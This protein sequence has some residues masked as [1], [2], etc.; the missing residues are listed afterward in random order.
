MTHANS[1]VFIVF[2]VLYWHRLETP[3]LSF[4]ELS[5]APSLQP[6]YK[7]VSSAWV[8][9]ITC[10]TADKKPLSGY[11]WLVLPTIH[12]WPCVTLEIIVI[13]KTD[14]KQRWRDRKQWDKSTIR[15]ARSAGESSFVVPRLF[16][17]MAGRLDNSGGTALEQV[18]SV[19]LNQSS[20]PGLTEEEL[21]DRIHTTLQKFLA[22]VEAKG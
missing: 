12:F 10:I 9:K 20:H 2:F 15:L 6:L 3:C 17:S 7:L 22:W 14:C 5:C 13:V 4:S 18:P 21:V 8:A 1:F 16:S 11:I 19:S